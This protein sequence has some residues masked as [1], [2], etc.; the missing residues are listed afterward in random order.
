MHWLQGFTYRKASTGLNRGCL[1]RLAW[2]PEPD[3]NRHGPFGPRDFKSINNH[4]QETLAGSKMLYRQIF[5]RWYGAFL[6]LGVGWFSYLSYSVNY[7]T[8][9]QQS[10]ESRSSQPIGKETRPIISKTVSSGLLIPCPVLSGA[11]VTI[12]VHCSRSVAEPATMK[13]S[14]AR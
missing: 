4:H 2:C 12:I 8:C 11:T 7:K 5:P 14:T 13:M 6:L 9:Q 1:A 10:N 3:S